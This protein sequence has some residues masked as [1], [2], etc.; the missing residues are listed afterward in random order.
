MEFKNIASEHIEKYRNEVLKNSSA[1]TFDRKIFSLKK[2]FEWAVKEGFLDENPVE[3][4]LHKEQEIIN[5]KL[6][7]IEK[8]SRLSTPS[9]N[10]V[11]ARIVAKFAGIPKLQKLAYGLF[12]TRPKWYKSYHNLPI[13]SY[14][15]YAI[16]IL[17]M[18]GLG[19]G[20]Y[21]QFFKT[22][23]APLA[24]PTSLTRAGR[25]LSFQGRLTNNLGNPITTSRDLVF[26][27]YSVDTGGSPL[28]DSSTCAITPDT[29]GIFSILLGSSCGAEIPA[30]VFSENSA[31]WL[32]VTV[33]TDTEATPRVQIATVAYALNSETLQGYPASMSATANTIP[34]INSSGFLVLGT[35]SPKIQSTSGTFA[36]EGQVMTITTP[37]LSNGSITINPD[38]TGTL[39]LTFEG[40]APGGSAG[41]FVNA[42]NANITSG[43]LYYGAVASG[44]TGYNLLQLQS[45]SS[46]TDKF[47]VDASGNI[48]A[49]GTINGVTISS[50][51][52]SS[53]TWNGTAIGTQYGGTGQDW[54]SVAQGSVPYFNGTGTMSTLAPGTGGYVLSTNGTGADPSW[55]SASSVGTNYWQRTL[56]SLTPLNI[57]DAL[58]LG[59]TAT[60]SALV[61]FTGT[62]GGSSWIN[63]GYFGIGTTTPGTKLDVDG[64]QYTTG[65]RLKNT[66][67]IAG[68]KSPNL[69]FTTTNNTSRYIRNTDDYLALV[70]TGGTEEIQFYDS[71]LIYTGG[72]VGIATLNPTALLDIAGNASTSGTLTFRGTTDPKIN[73][74]NGERFGIKTSPG[75]DDGL[76]ERLSLLSSGY[77]DLFSY[78]SDNQLR[79][80]RNS[81]EYLSII[82]NDSTATFLNDQDENTAGFGNLQF[83]TDDDGTSDG[84]IGFGTKSGTQYMRII[85]GGNVGIGTTSPS[86][87]LDIAGDLEV[88]GYATMSASLALGNTTASAGPGHL[89]MSGNLTAGGTINGL[90]V[91]SGTIS[92]GTWNGTAIGTQYG[93]T[94]QDWSSISQGS[95]PY[96]NGTGTMSTLAPGTSGY[97]LSTNGAGADPTWIEMSATG[98][99]YWQ[100]TLG[101]LAPLNITDSLN[102]GAIASSSA[103][104]HL[105]GT[106]GENSWINTGN[107]GVGTTSPGDKLDVNGNLRISG[108]TNPVFLSNTSLSS[109]SFAELNI[110][111]A[112]NNTS[113]L[114]R[115]YPKGTPSSQPTSTLQ[116]FNTDWSASQTNYDSLEF[117]FYNNVAQLLSSAGGTGTTR[118]IQITTGSNNGIYV[119]SSGQIG[120]GTLSPATNTGVDIVTNASSMW[121]AGSGSLRLQNTNTGNTATVFAMAPDSGSDF[122]IMLF[123]SGAS[124]ANKVILD[125]RNNAP[126]S[127]YTNNTERLTILGGGNIGIGTTNPSYALDIIS[128]SDL[129]VAGAGRTDGIQIGHV[130]VGNYEVNSIG[131]GQFSVVSTGGSLVLGAG[132][133]SD[134][135]KFRIA[136]AQKAVLDS[137]GNFGINTTTPTALLD[138]AGT[139]S[140]SGSLSFRAGAGVVGTTTMSDLT[141]GSSSTGNVVINSRGSTALTA[142]GV[143][144]TATG[145]VTL[146]NSNTLT[147]ISASYLQ[148]S[149]GLSVGGA[150]TY[151]FDSTGNLNANGGT[152][153]G[154][155]AVNGADLTTT[156]TGTAS[157][158]NTNA[159]TL[160]IGGAA[161]AINIGPA[162]STATSINLAGGSSDTGCTVSGATGNLVCS[163]NL[164]GLAVSSGTVSSGTWNGTA[165]GTQYGGTGQNWSSVA[166]G[167]IPYFNGTGTMSTLAPGTG[168]YVLSTNGA[169][170]NPTWIE[171]SA[172]GTNYW[173]L[174]NHVLAPANASDYD[175]AVGGNATASAKFLVNAATGNLITSG[176]ASVSGNLTLGNGSA[177][178]S[179]Y[180]PLTLNYK[181]GANTWAA[182]ITLQDTTGNVGIGTT[183]PGS[184][185]EV[186]GRIYQSGLGN[187]TFVGYEAGK[188]DDLTT[189]DNSALGYQALYSNIT[190]YNNNALGYQALYSNTTGYRNNALGSWALYSNTGGDYN[191]ALGDQALY[192]NTEGD[193]NNALGF[194]ALYLNTT[195]GNN[196]ALGYGALAGNTTGNYN[197]ALGDQ[198]GRYIADGST[199]NATS[200]YSI[201]LGANTKAYAD[202]DQ[203][204]IVIGY[205]TTG[206]GSNTATYGNSLMLSHIFQAGNV[207]IGTSS[208]AAKLH[209]SG[210][211]GGNA[212][213]IVDQ[214]LGGD[215]LTASASG[216]TKMTLTNDGTLKLYNSTSSISNTSGDITINPASGAVSFSSAAL[217]NISK[218]DVAGDATISGSLVFRGTSPATIDILN[219]DRLD[220]QT[221]V[222]GDT[223]LAAKMTLLN[224]GY[225]GIG[226]TS[227]TQMLDVNGY[228]RGQRF[229]DTSSSSYY[230]DPAASGTSIS[231]DGNIVSNGAFDI[232]SNSTNGDITLDAGSGSIV[233]V[234]KLDAGTID[235]PYTIDG[236]KYAT[237]VTSMT[238][239]KE[240]TTGN[241]TTSEYLAGEGYR[242]TLDFAEAASGSDLWLFSNTTKLSENFGDLVVLLSPSAN[243]K[244]WY[245]MDSSGKL[246]IYTSIPTTVSYR[247]TA[248]RFDSDSWT[249]NRNSDTA[250]FI[251]SDT[252]TWTGEELSSDPNQI[253]FE[254]LEVTI[255]SES[256]EKYNLADS[257]TGQ[258]V[259]E[260][261]GFSQAII[262]NIKAGAIETKELATDSFIAFQ[263]TV[264]N[265][266]VKSGLVA[267]NIQTKLISPIPDEDLAVELPQNSKFKIQD[268]SQNEVASIDSSGNATFSGTLYAEEIESKSL[269]EI[270]ALL[271]QVQTDQDLLAQA[272]TW[273][274]TA[275]NSANL[276]EIVTANLYVT[277][278]AAMNSLSLSQSLSIGSDFVIQSDLDTNYQ[279]LATSI[280]TL[281]SP[282]RI[283]S[284]AM[285]PVE[286]MA[287]LIKI[288][289]A[290]NVQ[291]AGNLAVAGN[292][293]SSS[294]NL[295]ASK[296]ATVSGNILSLQDSEGNMVSTVDASGSAVF[297]NISTQGLTIAGATEAT[298]SAVIDGVITTNATAGSGVIP[299]DLSE[300]TIKNPNVTDYTLVYVTPTSSTR[301]YVL[302]VKSKSPGEFVVGFTNPIEIDV[303][304]NWWIVKVTE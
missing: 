153:A 44:A 246:Y 26:K 250:G 37:D 126:L 188:N 85:D 129:R 61:H 286:I 110:Q 59:A 189:N 13:A 84:Y 289:T 302:F 11:Q 113:T 7:K 66:A 208:P 157:L 87:L 211:Y 156:S 106:S 121:G 274:I 63:T 112:S 31:I 252:N 12:Y 164:N 215:I 103:L 123:G 80:G 303:N 128:D 100:R 98:T 57:T 55:I 284:L 9:Y 282:L 206:F 40:A 216:S 1:S 132:S 258:I 204:E 226:T 105:A 74:L 293:E 207:G 256:A 68:D 43:A 177:L 301:N 268:S 125:Q 133:S 203:N 4:F 127:F 8:Q 292:I 205:N 255:S 253:T 248:P 245:S 165:I 264:D 3:E 138:V 82:V 173:Q 81:S 175:L 299:G 151:F 174:A 118:P 171:M 88:N 221:S 288:D 178:Q 10:S 142:N 262:A 97:V 279:L 220:F 48:T 141:L 281:T 180:G 276:D 83:N 181:S 143:N 39:N 212:S 104:V 15:N 182:G 92:S 263:G 42:T 170:A 160:N 231:I 172:T 136:G 67:G 149:A 179:T 23:S 109:T 60:T 96:F 287:G 251:I 290:G 49:A 247:L 51:T 234:G 176:T 197:N 107:L 135:I 150:T 94:G 131:T 139:A 196:N 219:G 163:G 155:V 140:V 78:G 269:D 232:T 271:T 45:G 280:N 270:Q 300:I 161:T 298:N 257:I 145:T 2:F 233:V 285:A 56:G 6:G 111:T 193:Y 202:N 283:Q 237:Y 95:I 230:V 124:P 194:A 27:L 147:G 79:I 304:F 46:L 117:R 134:E 90:T 191:N 73:I 115:L 297:N 217:G 213:L 273:D 62:A 265:M 190:G 58:N 32:G 34:A 254:N 35:S 77:L 72:N 29:D 239:V 272:S 240:E 36:I 275:S 261:A 38:G 116:L 244:A 120:L 296:E 144:L 295:V 137:S 76:V 41:G 50:G 5:T 19:F 238:G 148:F 242:A 146:P 294:L 260:L 192:Y 91:S 16:L 21:N 210:G 54:S 199:A 241:I 75:G 154:D 228:I 243:T 167:S 24:Y 22:T 277:D 69:T 267:G 52:I 53:S 33:G 291:I 168:G 28:W 102:L 70:D 187:S 64:L 93:G 17:L 183:S 89:D 229:E 158:F 184:K 266:L 249:N 166:Q 227:P 162:S 224:N 114:V 159:T 209:I 86:A 235:P 18:S 65:I 25:Y 71:Q 223:G 130:S 47:I 108:A 198:A 185:L 152:F 169:G 101:S 195:G 225:L 278:Q 14:F 200:D 218:I 222:G 236:S 119:N 122:D 214:T 186:A 30:S 99:N 201:Y 259:E 20:V